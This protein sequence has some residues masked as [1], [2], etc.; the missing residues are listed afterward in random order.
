MPTTTPVVTAFELERFVATD[1]RLEV[2]G[3][4]VGVRGR[5]FI[6][7][8]LIAAIGDGSV[9]ALASLE[10]KP[11]APDEDSTW[12]AAF[13][14]PANIDEV[15]EF[16]LAVAPDLAVMLP[17]QTRAPQDG[18]ELTLPA[19][20]PKIEKKSGPNQELPA[21]TKAKPVR[22]EGPRAADKDPKPKRSPLRASS[23]QH[24]LEL[25]AAIEAHMR[26]VESRN[27]ALTERDGAIAAKDAT[28]RERDRVRVEL[29]AVDAER[30]EA[31]LQREVAREER[32]AARGE[33]NEAVAK[34]DEA[35][36]SH[37]ELTVAFERLGTELA[38][39]QAE[40]ERALVEL[41]DTQSELAYVQ[42]ELAQARSDERS[43][44]VG[45]PPAGAPGPLR[46]GSIYSSGRAP[47]WPTRVLTMAA[48]LV[49]IVL[50][51]RIVT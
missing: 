7:P 37:N 1:G 47:H 5:R 44:P 4:W 29:Q 49:T 15:E 32:D 27:R 16:E 36:A 43:V 25:R 12:T 48:M 31:H 41:A 19:V 9:R 45:S 35:I 6:R 33:L 46:Y 8:N 38:K 26:A 30:D 51:L 10:H 40:R 39:A 24:E 14:W 28:I 50:L 11:W 2:E 18:R 21:S 17:S 23:S 22:D 20:R 3:R 13:P 42:A 34:R